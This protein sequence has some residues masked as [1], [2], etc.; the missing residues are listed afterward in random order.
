MRASRRSRSVVSRCMDALSVF[1]VT[2]R[3]PARC[4]SGSDLGAN[5]FGPHPPG[6][7]LRIFRNPQSHLAGSAPPPRPLHL[8]D[9]GRRPRRRLLW[10]GLLRGPPLCVRADRRP[11]C[12][13]VR[14]RDWGSIPSLGVALAPA[15]K[16]GA[17]EPGGFQRVRPLLRAPR[18]RGHS[19][20]VGGHTSEQTTSSRTSDRGTISSPRP[21]RPLPTRQRCSARRASR[22]QPS[23]HTFGLLSSSADE[24]RLRRPRRGRARAWRISVGAAHSILGCRHVSAI[25][26]PGGVGWPRSH[27]HGEQPT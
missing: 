11:V 8:G 22:R 25:R 12:R 9:T 4:A 1:V 19:Q 6:C 24:L 15:S 20:R 14:A 5:A 27:M 26:V 2:A 23:D 17:N 18:R 7:R 3:Y 16:C 10:C 21:T 13:G